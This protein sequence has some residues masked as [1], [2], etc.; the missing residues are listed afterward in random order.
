MTET[1]LNVRVQPKA[2]RSEVAGYEA[3]VLRVSIAAPPVEGK[4]NEELIAFLA[5]ALGVRR[6][7]I[8]LIHGEKGR[9]KV[10]AVS[11]LSEEEA[12]E[13]LGLPR[14]S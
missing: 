6:S 9:N 5:R 11:G 3:G 7:D 8:T 1:R 13:R 4:A 12:L 14:S 10:L 2:S